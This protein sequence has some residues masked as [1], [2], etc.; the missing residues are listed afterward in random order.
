[1]REIE[2]MQLT[3]Y[4]GRN[5]TITTNKGDRKWDNYLITERKRFIRHGRKAEIRTK[6]REL[7]LFVDR[8]V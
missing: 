3:E 5:F 7:A 6:G 4:A 2:M 1:M 8:I